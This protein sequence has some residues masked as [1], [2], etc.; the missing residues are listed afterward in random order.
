MD[1]WLEMYNLQKWG[2]VNSP[3]IARNLCLYTGRFKTLGQ[4]WS[5]FLWRSFGS[6]ML[7]KFLQIRHRFVVEH[8]CVC[9]TFV[10]VIVNFCKMQTSYFNTTCHL[11]YLFAIQETLPFVVFFR[12]L[13]FEYFS[14][15]LCSQSLPTF[16]HPLQT[17]AY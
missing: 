14:Y 5:R 11:S 6:E 8:F 2:K 7:M 10:T 16:H 12:V 13:R 15:R 3:C 4:Y 9:V 1:K 17:N